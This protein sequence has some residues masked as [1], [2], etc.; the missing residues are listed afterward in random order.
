MVLAADSDAAPVEILYRR[1][2]EEGRTDILPLA[3][4]IIDA[5]PGLGWRGRER[6]RLEDR[7]APDL[8][9]CLALLHHV[10]IT[11]NVPVAEYLDPWLRSL[12]TEIVIEFVRREDPMVKQL[13]AAKREETHPDYDEAFFERCPRRRLHRAAPR[14]AAVRDAGPLPRHAQVSA[15][16]TPPPPPPPPPP[17]RAWRACTC[18]RSRHSPSRSRC[19]TSSGATRRSSPPIR[20]RA[21]TSC[22]SRSC[23]CS[24]PP[25]VLFAIEA[26]VTG[27]INQRARQIVHLV[28]V[29]ALTALFALPASCAGWAG[30][31]S[32]RSCWRWRWVRAARTPTTA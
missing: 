17:A 29:G 13:L 31:R 22:S 27:L 11:G 9:L 25:L 26:V 23:C 14:G 12:E 24:L 2:R 5:S 1:L 30:R 19:S 4:D 10:S 28:F 7:G 21:S 18:W 32:R 16:A 8:V 6:R 15:E 3:L 20:S